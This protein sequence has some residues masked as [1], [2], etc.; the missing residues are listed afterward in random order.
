M[1]QRRTILAAA[2]ASAFATPAIAQAGPLSTRDVVG[3]WTLTMTP[4]ERSDL[5][6]NVQSGDGGPAVLPVTVTARPDGRLSCLV[7]GDRADCR[8]RD[9]RLVI[10]SGRG[11]ARMTFTVADRT[12]QGLAG[13]ASLRVRLLPIGGRIGDVTMVRR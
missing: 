6:I 7:R 13:E 8:L 2:L 11:G 3:D 5:Q 10:V 1:A 9:G 4:A 12:P